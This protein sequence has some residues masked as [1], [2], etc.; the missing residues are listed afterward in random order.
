MKLSAM[1]KCSHNACTYRNTALV[2]VVTQIVTGY[3][4]NMWMF[5]VPL[6]S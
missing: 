6:L 5:S 4:M 1:I 3:F 2:D